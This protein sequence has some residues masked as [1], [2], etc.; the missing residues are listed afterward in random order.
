MKADTG[1]YAAR[2]TLASALIHETVFRMRWLIFNWRCGLR[3]G[4]P[5]CCV[6]RFCIEN[7]VDP[8]RPQG[9][10][11][12]ARWRGRGYVACGFLHEGAVLPKGS[13]DAP[14]LK[15]LLLAH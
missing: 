14:A 6:I 1:A 11:R 12:Y 5:S 3:E 15:E 2:R 8:R 9:H 10:M 13:I 7:L 4:Y